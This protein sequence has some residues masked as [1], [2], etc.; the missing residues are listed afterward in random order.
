MVFAGWSLPQPREFERVHKGRRSTQ[1]DSAGPGRGVG[2]DRRAARPV[3]PGR[4][5]APLRRRA[6]QAA[7]G[8]EGG[9]RGTARS[10]A[11]GQASGRLVEVRSARPGTRPGRART[12][13]G[14]CGRSCPGLPPARRRGAGA[15]LREAG[16]RGP[17]QGGP[18][19]R[20]DV[21]G[22]K[23][24][25]CSPHF[26]FLTERIEES[27]GDRRTVLDDYAVASRLSYFLWSSMP[28]RELLELAGRGACASPRSC[29]RRS[30]DC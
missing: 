3:A 17:R 29:G 8:R 15:L 28:D 26:L 4:L 23:A 14:C 30:S 19:R 24:A 5:S 13:N 21:L 2:R 10:A 1:S 11:T 12:P 7:V 6:A 22:Y 20:G 18:V 9:G 16:P 27:R 25:L